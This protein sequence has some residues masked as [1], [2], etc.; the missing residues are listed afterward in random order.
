MST[1]DS[2]IDRDELAKVVADL[3]P[4][5]EEPPTPENGID[6]VPAPDES[7]TGSAEALESTPEPE[8]DPTLE[9]SDSENAADQI[10]L[11]DPSVVEPSVAEVNVAEAEAEAEPQAEIE[12]EGRDFSHGSEILGAAL[13]EESGEIVTEEDAIDSEITPTVET[14]ERPSELEM[15]SEPEPE[16][17]LES[18]GSLDFDETQA[19]EAAPFPAPTLPGQESPVSPLRRTAAVQAAE[20]LERARDRAQIGGLLKPSPSEAV[21]APAESPSLPAP[22]PTEVEA[23]EEL[24][25]QD[26]FVATEESPGV[27]TAAPPPLPVPSEPVGDESEILATQENA[28]PSG[29]MEVEETKATESLPAAA[30]PINSLRARLSA[31]V[32]STIALTGADSV[33]LSDFQSYPLLSDGDPVTPA[34]S[35]LRLAHWYGLLADDLNATR[36]GL[37]QIA[38]SEGRWLCVVTAD[39]QA[40]GACAS[41][42]AGAPVPDELARQLGADL[43]A[44]LG[45]PAL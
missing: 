39:S 22:M 19:Y 12:P 3:V 7:A 41:F 33:A 31:F 40:G 38:L 11:T 9:E 29:S 10:P 37:V 5:P 2:W 15:I 42:L 36:D 20:A 6:E 23:G 32:E 25:D 8:V 14:A 13:T 4:S 21:E 44:A 18:P 30:S 16:T 35:A 45:D 27:K 1:L 26:S 34:H 17:E 28:A 24:D 43:R